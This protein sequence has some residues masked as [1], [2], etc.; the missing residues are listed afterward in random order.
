MSDYTNSKAA[1]ACWLL[2]GKNTTS[3]L[4]QLRLKAASGMGWEEDEDNM[5]RM[6]MKRKELD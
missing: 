5:M 4:E 1:L 6:R 3:K 2:K